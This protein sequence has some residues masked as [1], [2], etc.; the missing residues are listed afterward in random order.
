[1][2]GLLDSALGGVVLDAAVRGTFII[3]A[4]LGATALMRRTSA[5]ARHL[6]WLAALTALML[7]PFARR[8]VPEWRVLPVPAAVL[9]PPA[10]APAPLHPAPSLDVRAP[11]AGVMGASA[12]SADAAATQPF[13]I[14][15][16][17]KT[18]AL[19]AWAAGAA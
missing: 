19:L 7:L 9:A 12:N 16:D 8:F 15:A 10:A 2:N 1:M 5:S 3:L 18:W 11:A 14:P 4:A 6:V 17:W 13:R